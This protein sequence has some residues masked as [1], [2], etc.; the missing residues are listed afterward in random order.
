MPHFPNLPPRL[1]GLAD[2]AM[3][4]AWSWSREARALF[5][6]VNE[7]LWHE[8]R[9]NPL[10]LLRRADPADLRSRAADPEYVAF[11]DAVIERFHRTLANGDAWFGREFGTDVPGPV[12]YFCA[13]FGLHN[14]VPIYSG[15]LG[16]LAGD[17][18]K[19]ASDLAVPLIGVGLFYRRGYFDQHLR[20][21]GWQESSDVNF[22]VAATPL[23]PL[24]GPDGTPWLATVQAFGRTVHVGAWRL[25]VGRV[26]VYLL[27]TDYEANDPADRTLVSKL[28]SGGPDHRIRQEWVLGVGGC[29]CCAPWASHRRPG[30][31]TKGTPRS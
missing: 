8:V 10:E 23:V 9:H 31:P 30:T 7:T 24:P 5:A 14:S 16:V 4:L 12:A 2:L 28:Y 3:N 26:P 6:G 1:S 21:D 20:L 19:A 15:G 25:Q 29:A 18:C 11:Y 13:E 17:H 22:D 27:D